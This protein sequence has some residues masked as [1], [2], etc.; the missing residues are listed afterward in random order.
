M[1]LPT[2]D[3]RGKPL[4]QRISLGRPLSSYTKLRV[5]YGNLIRGRTFQL[6][7]ASL[8]TKQLLNVGCGP[9]IIPQFI[10]LDYSWNPGLDLCWDLCQGIPLADHSIKALYSEHCLEHLSFDNCL[11]T[12]REFKRVL[13]PGGT[14]RIVVP[15]AELYLDLYQR[16]KAG[17][18]VD[19]PYT[20]SPLPED[21]TPLMAINHI[22]FEH[23]H[24]YAYDSATMGVLLGKAGF[25]DVKKET[26]MKGRDNS[27]LI[28]SPSREVESLYMEAT[29]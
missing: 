10:N 26:F 11:Q 24:L 28:D 8:R 12:L 7:R 16:H 3:L 29:A 1:S 20:A 19:F 4:H 6:K 27:L 9:N 25:T 18:Q 2:P 17:E 14:V 15:D 23:G 13:Q 21:V 5:L 22:F